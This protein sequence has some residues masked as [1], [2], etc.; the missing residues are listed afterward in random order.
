MQ[1]S[2]DSE[3]TPAAAAAAAA[4]TAVKLL[5]FGGGK[6]RVAV[7]A[8]VENRYIEDYCFLCYLSSCALQKLLLQCALSQSRMHVHVI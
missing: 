4:V 3:S 2:S 7:E 5:Q 6:R 8:E 1:V